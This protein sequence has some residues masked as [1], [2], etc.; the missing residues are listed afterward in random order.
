MQSWIIIISLG[1]LCRAADIIL[2]RFK[3]G[4]VALRFLRKLLWLFPLGILGN[5]IEND[6]LRLFNYSFLFIFMQIPFSV[7][8]QSLYQFVGD[9]Y[10]RLVYRGKSR[11]KS[12]Y[13]QKGDYILPFIGKWTVFNGGVNAG[14]HHGGSISQKYAY[15][16]IIANDEGKSFEGDGRAVQ[17]YFCYDKAVVAP[18]DGTIVVAKK[19][20]K[21]SFVD[22]LTAYCD[23]FDLRGN[24][25]VIKH[26]DNE[27]SLT[28]HLAPNSITVNV[29]D[30]VKQGDVIAKCGNT[31]NSSEP[32][33]H[34]QLQTG[35]SFFL[36]AGLPIAFS[37]IE[38]HDKA[39]YKLMDTR[40]CENNLEVVG[41]RTYI[42][43]GL[44]VGNKVC[45]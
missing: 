44:E 26:H 27:Y 22:G 41:D 21:D 33:I 24:Y 12:N 16:F 34:F 9:I 7:F 25:I 37:N 11:S 23:S 2:R 18:A 36:S 17:N 14:L 4:A 29:G 19:K 20:A 6:I 40:P 38:A 13:V 10:V 3:A 15:D 35:K 1:L 30:Q 8:I 28:A 31:G 32:H 45:I 43:R 39:N 5:F 42:G